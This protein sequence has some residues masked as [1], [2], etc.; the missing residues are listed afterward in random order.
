MIG[1]YSTTGLT[2]NLTSQNE[3][4]LKSLSFFTHAF[5]QNETQDPFHLECLCAHVFVSKRDGEKERVCFGTS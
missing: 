3:W 4:L 5:T 2:T 1:R